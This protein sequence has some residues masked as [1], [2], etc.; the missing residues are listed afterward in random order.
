MSLFSTLFFFASCLTKIG[1][2]WSVGLGNTWTYKNCSCFA[3]LFWFSCPPCP[4]FSISPLPPLIAFVSRGEGEIK[5]VTLPTAINKPPSFPHQLSL[6]RLNLFL[7]PSSSSNPS[8]Q[9][10]SNPIQSFVPLF[11]VFCLGRYIHPSS[12]TNKTT[13]PPRWRSSLPLSL[14][15]FVPLMGTTASNFYI[16]HVVLFGSAQRKIVDRRK[17]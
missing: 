13:V 15:P 14:C 4:F 3:F 1:E 8:F 11:T 9:R 2:G 12:F 16:S 6:L 17:D 5:T 10:A 7:R